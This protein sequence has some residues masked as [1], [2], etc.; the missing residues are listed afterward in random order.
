MN[1]AELLKRLLPP[2]AYDPSAPVLSAELAAEGTALDVAQQLAESLPDEADPR[3]TSALLA[4]W[5]RVLGLTASGL[6]QEQRKAAVA[7][8]YYTRGAQSRAYFI[9]LAAKLGFAGV[10]IT[11]YKCANC[12]SNCNSAL[13]SVADLFVWTLNVLAS[14]GYFAANCNSNCNSALGSWGYSTLE[15]AIKKDKPAHTVATF[16]YI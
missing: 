7:A 9:A 3:V 14:G 4:D 15:N 5:E 11:E 16:N 13:Y 12:N 10:T 2:A 6:S 8:K 1:N